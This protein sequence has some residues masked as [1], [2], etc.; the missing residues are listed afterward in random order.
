MF[1]VEGHCKTFEM[2]FENA[3]VSLI[4]SSI[5]SENNQFR[6]LVASQNEMVTKVTATESN[7]SHF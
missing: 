7:L 5:L 2:K 6:R 4:T 3:A 1:S